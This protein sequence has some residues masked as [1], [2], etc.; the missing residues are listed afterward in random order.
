MRAPVTVVTATIPGREVLL[1]ECVQSVYTQTVEV[2]AHLVLAQSC[3]EGLP[4]PVHCAKMQNA[5]LWAVATE[6]TMRL[7]D[8]DLLL[9][10]HIATLLPY[11]GERADVIYSWDAS[12][13]RPRWNA[14]VLSQAQLVAA[15]RQTSW[16]DGSAVAIRSSWLKEVGGWPTSYEGTPPF[17]GHFSGFPPAVTC[18]DHACFLR[19]A[20]TG[21]RF[22]C[23]PE[24]TWVYRAGRWPR[25]SIEEPAE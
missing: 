16:I 9:P 2:E 8:D 18:E 19:L 4:G 11:F 15:L 10:H 21:A 14:N 23:V 25:I 13:N 7:A 12:E 5:L 6:W 1:T 3:T 20:Q 24:E 17:A 22:L